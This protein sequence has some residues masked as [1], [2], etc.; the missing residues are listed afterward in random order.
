MSLSKNDA[1]QV[2]Q[3]V[4]EPGSTSTSS[5]STSSLKIKGQKIY[6]TSSSKDFF[7]DS[8]YDAGS[9]IKISGF[10][11][12]YR[13]NNRI[14]EVVN[15]ESGGEWIQVDK[16][17]KDVTEADMPSVTFERSPNNVDISSL[18]Q[19]DITIND[20]LT[21]AVN[22]KST[23]SSPAVVDETQMA[24]TDTNQVSSFAATNSGDQVLVTIADLSKG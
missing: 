13:E 16:E 18:V 22:F 4:I 9:I 11:D 5:E 20:V 24:I 19:E 12:Q 21:D 23:S 14:F 10:G 6:D 15:K 8:G 7:S 1:E 17:I 3:I 2:K